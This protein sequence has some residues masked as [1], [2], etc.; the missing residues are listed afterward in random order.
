MSE[1]SDEHTPAEKA[2]GR[3]EYNMLIRRFDDVDRANAEH[4][5]SHAKI[6]TRCDESFTMSFRAYQIAKGAVLMR[7]T[8]A[9]YAFSLALAVATALIVI[10]CTR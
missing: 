3:R 10:A 6:L 8:W 2:L 7:S 5:R 4:T 9:P 1:H